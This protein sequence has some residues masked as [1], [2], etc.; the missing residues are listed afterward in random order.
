MVS[1]LGLKK[2]SCGDWRK[3]PGGGGRK[4]R[5]DCLVGSQALSREGKNRSKVW[6]SS[7]LVH[8]GEG[9]ARLLSGKRK[10]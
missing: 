10:C 5:A 1:D 2:R 6:N 7:C 3:K 4:V 9:A 8:P